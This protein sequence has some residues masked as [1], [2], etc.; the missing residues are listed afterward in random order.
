MRGLLLGGW[1]IV[2]FFR[3]RGTKGSTRTA[4]HWV[5]MDALHLYV[6]HRERV[7]V[8]PL[9]HA[10]NAKFKHNFNNGKYQNSTVT[11]WMSGR[12]S[13]SF[14]VNDELRAEAVRDV[15]QLRGLGAGRRGG[16]DRRAFAGHAGRGRCA[17]WRDTTFNR[18]TPKGSSTWIYWMSRSRTFLKSQSAKDAAAPSILPYVAM[19]VAVILLFPFMAF[20]VNP[21]V[22][23][24]AIFAAVT[25]DPQR[26]EPRFLRPISSTSATRS[27]ARRSSS[28]SP[29]ITTRSSITSAPTPQQPELKNGMLALLESLREEPDQPIVSLR[30][31]ERSPDT[32]SKGAPARVK[33]LREGIVGGD[34]LLGA[35]GNGI[36]DVFARVSPPIQP[37]PDVVFTEKPPPI[38]HQLIDFVQPP[39][40]AQHAHIHIIYEFKDQPDNTYRLAVTVEIR[41]KVD[42]DPIAAH[43]E[44]LPGLYSGEEASTNAITGLRDLV[45]QWMVGQ[46]KNA[47]VPFAPLAPFAP[48][49]PK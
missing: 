18:K 21:P 23:D 42:G 45:V 43:T 44:E 47:N 17:T 49:P 46:N 7:T 37:P 30:V 31:T 10:A 20:V 9:E 6:A 25:H 22:R 15:R 32:L 8:I 29:D 1:L 11:I 33:K 36:L 28:S 34:G 26:T 5:Y 39:E 48:F 3:F 2:A 27:I 16:R 13:T 38:G 19:L 40:D 35:N 24:D 4:G 14:A 12:T 41:K